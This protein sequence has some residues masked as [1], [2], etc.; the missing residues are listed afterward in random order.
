MM[1]STGTQTVEYFIGGKHFTGTC[2]RES[3]F[4]TT[5]I[6]NDEGIEVQ[7]LPGKTY[8]ALPDTSRKAE[9]TA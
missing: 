8:I 6:L 4:T 3:I 2:E 1:A 9:H 7:Y 5:T